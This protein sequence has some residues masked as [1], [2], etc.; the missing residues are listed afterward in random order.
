MVSLA[1]LVASGISGRS[2]APNSP[3][4]LLNDSGYSSSSCAADD[5]DHEFSDGD[6]YR[7]KQY[8]RE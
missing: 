1:Y 3:N 4:F 2:V 5:T 8:S 7:F 6:F